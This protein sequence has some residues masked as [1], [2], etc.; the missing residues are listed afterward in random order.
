VRPLGGLDGL[1]RSFIAKRDFHEFVD[2]FPCTWRTYFLE[3]SSYCTTKVH[4]SAID[5]EAFDYRSGT[6][7][8]EHFVSAISK[9]PGSYLREPDSV[10]ASAGWNR[11]P[12]QI[13]PWAG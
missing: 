11:H 7:Y 4:G 10:E 6:P 1:Y 5:F 8:F 9:V 2:F 3:T 12:L 13:Q